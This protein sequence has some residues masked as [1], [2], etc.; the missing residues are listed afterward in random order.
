MPDN[1]PRIERSVYEW[2][3]YPKLYCHFCGKRGI[4]MYSG[5]CFECQGHEEQHCPHC[6][7]QLIFR[8][9]DHDYEREKREELLAG[10]ALFELREPPKPEP[11]LSN[12]QR[13]MKKIP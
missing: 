6:E 9:P 1:Q 4:F 2:D 10:G 3:Y 12:V 7:G 5:T 13:R 8:I 11:P